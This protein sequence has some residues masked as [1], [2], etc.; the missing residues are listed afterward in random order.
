MLEI[1]TGRQHPH[2]QGAL[3]LKL[4]QHA[5]QNDFSRLAIIVP[6]KEARRALRILIA[7]DW[8]LSVL[9]L[10]LQT[11]FNF[12]QEIL[13]GNS[14]RPQS[15]A[16]EGILSELIRQLVKEHKLTGLLPI[17][18]TNGGPGALL[19]SLHTLHESGLSPSG[20]NSTSDDLFRIYAIFEA[21]R[22]ELELA[23]PADATCLAARSLESSAFV[24]NLAGVFYYGFYETTGVQLKLLQALSRAQTVTFFMPA[25]PCPA[26]SFA[27]E[28][29]EN[30]LSPLADKIT[31]ASVPETPQLLGEVIENLFQ[32]LSQSCPESGVEISRQTTS[33]T[34]AELRAAARQVQAL[35]EDPTAN[36]KFSDIV[37]TARD[38]TAYL[39]W[40]DNVMTEHHIPFRSSASMPG[41]TLP[42]VKALHS[43]IK[44]IESN[45]SRANLMNLLA[46]PFFAFDK[47]SASRDWVPYWDAITRQEAIC[48]QGDWQKLNRLIARSKQ[49]NST[50]ETEYLPGRA[51]PLKRNE[52]ATLQRIVNSL[53]ALLR[54]VPQQGNW[55]TMGAALLSG[56]DHHLS[57]TAGNDVRRAVQNMR[58]YSRLETEVSRGD[59]FKALRGEL[60]QLTLALGL[61]EAS[62]VEILDT[63]SL[64]CRSFRAVILIGMH[65][66]SFPRTVRQDPFLSDV[67]RKQI[68]A[69]NNCR[70]P[71][72]ESGNHEE[73]LLLALTLE[74]ATEHLTII[75]QRSDDG[76]KPLVPSW[77]LQEIESA[78]GHFPPEKQKHIPRRLQDRI[79][80][81]NAIELQELS[82]QERLRGL[83]LSGQRQTGLLQALSRHPEMLKYSLAASDSMGLTG[84]NLTASDG[85]TG[86]L[87]WV[88][89][90][91]KLQRGLSA[92]YLQSYARC[93]FTFFA[94][95]VLGLEPIEEPEEVQ[96]PA[97]LEYGEIIH[98]VLEQ[99]FKTVAE[100]GQLPDPDRAKE[101]LE[102]VLSDTFAAFARHKAT[103]WPLLWKRAQD[104]ISNLLR[105]TLTQE[106]SELAQSDFF[107]LE[108]ECPRTAEI[109][110][111]KDLPHEVRNLRLYGRIDRLDGRAAQGTA[112]DSAAREL[113]VVDYKFK[114]GASYSDGRL[115][116]ATI[117]GQLLQPPIYALLAAAHEEKSRCA[118]VQFHYIAP[119][120]K[121]GPLVVKSFPGDCWSSSLGNQVARVIAIIL[122]G[123]SCGEFFPLPSD[124]A[125]RYCDFPSICRKSH[126]ATRYRINADSLVI[127]VSTLKKTPAYKSPKTKPATN[128]RSEKKK[129]KS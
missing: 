7:R 98:S 18:E 13:S 54:N 126:R 40:L 71:L 62:G 94:E 97:A 23:V 41:G 21:R 72:K 55:N 82:Q 122:K 89:G 27:A 4:Q 2:L 104:E 36:L 47:F 121:N 10:H 108:S 84:N 16:T 1:I 119:N 53:T 69:N 92:T 38:L 5:A 15:F 120:W 129:D 127:P 85:I 93:P 100:Q 50:E 52:I 28:F 30:A 20:N 103:G 45:C 83:L 11:A 31:Q 32:P 14:Q 128:V 35:L 117:R 22:R 43:L 9:G 123:I 96:E 6:S 86:P 51:L 110:D 46:S 49:Q 81:N 124:N 75:S 12:S 33:G 19:K 59:F 101:L 105:T 109:P 67:A 90:P 76:G 34:E 78:G 91:G 56:I 74:A 61:A 42:A 114:S 125:C 48:G 88:P 37:V 68:S 106:I 116:T 70:L 24:K 60:S 64:R 95:K 113:R 26:Y 66:G 115:E 112:A 73:R 99:V 102:T 3:K 25:D 17:I 63:M 111:H 77:Y 44:V 80:G 57:F 58:G 118:A 8:Q 87:D 65:Q 107:P 79:S 29:M 39:P